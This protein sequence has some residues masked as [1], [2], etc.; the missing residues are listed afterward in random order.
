MDP[1]EGELIGGEAGGPVGFVRVAGGHEEGGVDLE[2]PG[3]ALDGGGG[4][5]FGE[6]AGVG[7]LEVRFISR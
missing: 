2:T 1:G 6:V 3:S 4:G 5:H 7:G